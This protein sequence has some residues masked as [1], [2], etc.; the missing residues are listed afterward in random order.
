MGFTGDMERL[1]SII[2]EFETDSLDMEKSL[3]L[4]EEGVKQIPECREYLVTAQRKVTM[5]ADGGVTE[6][7]VADE[8]AAG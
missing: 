4:F 7:A 1:Q 6:E 3:A 5:L 2:E 8:V